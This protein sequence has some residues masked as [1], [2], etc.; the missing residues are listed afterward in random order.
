MN[1]RIEKIISSMTVEE[2]IAFSSGGSFWE[3]KKYEKYGIPALFMC[4]GPHGVRKQEDTADMLGVN[5]SVPATCF[6][7]EV[8]RADSWNENLEEE[9]GKSVGEEAAKENVGLVLGPGVNIKRNP[10]CGRNFEYYSEDPLLSGRMGAAFIRGIE[11]TGVASSL[12]HFAVNSQERSRFNSNSV[13]DARTLREIYLTAFEIAVKEGR[14]STVMCAY[15]LLN[16]VHCSDNTMLLARTLREEWG[17]K[18]MVVTDWGGLSDRTEAF[19]AGC[20]LSMPGGS[21]YMEKETL[22]AVREGKLSEDDI[23]NSVRRILEV[24]FKAEETLRKKTFCDYEKHH[25]K[26]REAAEEGAVLLKNEDSILPLKENGSV[27]VIGKMAE[28]MRYQ[29]SGSSHINAKRVSQPIDYVKHDY[30]VPGYDERGNTTD[31]DIEKVREVSRNADRVL[32]FAGLPPHAESEG[33][34]RDDMKM[35]QGQIRVIEEAAEANENTVVVLFTGS[36]VECDWEDKVK[37]ILYMGLPGEAGGEAV[38]N[39]L[40][41]KVNPSGKLSES[42]PLKYGDV[43]SSEIYAKTK[44]ALYEEG[45]YVGYRCYDKADISVRWPFGFGLSYTSFSYSD[46]TAESNGVSVTVTN[47]G[48]REGKEV[49]QLYVSLPGSSIHRSRR[50]LRGFQKISLRPGE[51]RRVFLPF[52]SYTFRVWNDGWKEEKG[53]YTLTVGAISTTLVRDGDTLSNEPDIKG[54]WYESCKGKPSREEWERT[55][56]IRYT[57]PVLRKGGF[58]MDNSVIEMKDYSLIM[59]IMF[60]AVEKTVAKGYG[61]RKAY[62]DPNFR[63]QMASSAGAPLRSMHISGGMKGGVLPGMLMM[64][65]GHFIKGILK[66]IRG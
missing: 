37:G 54:T 33:F 42:W 32:V 47:T 3:T 21:D 55:T 51:S 35:P 31:A 38:A 15:P 41:G 45:I 14:P 25:E 16:G 57:E 62:D 12:K 46:L 8:T 44:D 50:E 6:P 22:R 63:M 66:M 48:K 17:S 13:V 53:T 2:K 49:I 18:A 10:L 61:G 39:L 28:D 30:F 24:V 1:D 56:G 65:N 64:A 7:S 5:N 60:R 36:A 4:D 43:P 29:G 40:Y 58:T 52:D 11:S 27:A 34:D 26:A 9:I 23:D 20:D 19:K 59:K